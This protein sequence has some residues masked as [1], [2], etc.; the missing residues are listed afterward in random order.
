MTTVEELITLLN[1]TPHPE[2]GYYRESYRSTERIP[3]NALPSRYEGDRAYSTAI[4]Y[5]L[6][7]NTYSALHRLKTDEVYH[8]Y[9]GDPVEMLQLLPDGRGS[10]IRLGDEV[11]S[12]MHLQV[13]VPSGVWQGSRLILGGECALL[14][15]TVAPGFEFAD[16]EIGRRSELL[17][18]H[19][20]FRDLIVAL[21]RE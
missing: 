21:T 8:F 12:G 7:S 19:P 10:V 18:S 5:L 4:Y 1:L 6:T 20:R 14:G 9:L 13:A 3:N 11:K 17:L 2:G 15:T 16:F